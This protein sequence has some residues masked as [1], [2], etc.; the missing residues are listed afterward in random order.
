MLATEQVTR[1]TLTADDQ[2]RL[3]EEA[4]RRGRLLGPCRRR[5]ERGRVAD[6]GDR[7][8]LRGGAVR[9]R[10]GAGQARR[11]PRAAR[12]VRRRALDATATCRSSSSA[13]T[14]RR[15]RSGTGSRGRSAAPSPE[16]VNFLELLAEKH[17]MPALFRIRARFDELWAK[18]NKRLDGDRDQRGRARPERRRGGRRPRSSSRPGRR[19]SCTSGVDDGIIGGLVLQVGQHGPRREHPQPPRE[20]AQGG[21][22]GG[23]AATGA[24]ASLISKEQGDTSQMEIKPDEIASIL[25]QRI[26]G[27]ETGS[28]DLSEVGTVL[29]V[30]R[31]HRPRP[32]PRQLHGARDARAARTT[33]PASRSTSRRTTSASCCSA[34]GTRSSRATPVKRTGQLLEIPVGEELLGRVVDPLG[35]PLDDK[36]DDQHDRD[37]PGRVQGAGRGPAPAGRRSRCRPASRRSTR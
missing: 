24:R 1:K 30:G 6:G 14:S 25:R 3:V 34:S 36:G 16:L 17:R 7:P 11:G 2:Q 4:L 33:S 32:R 10:Q 27:L 35:R 12:R 21:R 13:P 37:A 18:E 22:A 15:R 5:P 26:E 9:R 31:R 28:A 19:S 23:L 20:A 8:R 29:S